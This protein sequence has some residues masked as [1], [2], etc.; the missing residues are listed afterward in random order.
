[1]VSRRSSSEE[2]RARFGGS[3]LI[4]MWL[5]YAHPEN[6]RRDKDGK[7]AVAW[8]TRKELLRY[9]VSNAPFPGWKVLHTIPYHQWLAESGAVYV[10]ER[11]QQ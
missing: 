7:I 4:D 5:Q 11:S 10:L 3:Y 1:M 6:A 8:M 2:R 9:Q